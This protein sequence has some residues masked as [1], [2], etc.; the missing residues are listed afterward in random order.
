MAGEQPLARDLALHDHVVGPVGEALDDPPLVARRL[1]EDGVENHDQ[2]R[3]QLLGQL[4]DILAV[5]PREEPE[6]VLEDHRVVAVESVDR[7]R[8]GAARATHPLGDHLRGAGGFPGASTQ[9]TTPIR[10]VRVSARPSD[11][12]NVASPQRVGGNVLTNPMRARVSIVANERDRS[13]PLRACAERYAE[14]AIAPPETGRLSSA[15][16][17]PNTCRWPRVEPALADQFT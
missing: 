7:L 15:L 14:T 3:A 10:A 1:L 5:G 9:A 12:V 13:G 16:G 2:R 4:E 6:L 11:A 8:E 17:G